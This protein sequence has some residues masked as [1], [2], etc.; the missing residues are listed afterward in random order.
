MRIFAIL[1]MITM[2]SCTNKKET[3]DK[4]EIKDDKEIS[5]VGTWE[6]IAATT[7]QGDSLTLKD[8]Q[9]K[10]MIKIIND[11]HFSFLN[12]D[13]NKEKDSLNFYVSGGGNYKLSGNDYTEYLEYCTARGW[14]GNKFEFKIE[15][16]GDTLIQKGIEEIK[17]LGV[18]REI[19]EVYLR[20][21]E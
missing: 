14:E 4:K 12:H 16:H 5:L 10:K 20:L 21:K 1:L 9:N 8:L 19:T 18:D 15:I 13:I 17:D 3:L 2:L 6:L 11:T 7:L